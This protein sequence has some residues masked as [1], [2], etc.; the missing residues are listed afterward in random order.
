MR[1][2]VVDDDA[3]VRTLLDL[4]LQ[5]RGHEVVV[6]ASGAEA[7]AACAAGAFD[8]VLLDVTLPVFSVADL[9]DVLADDGA[10]PPRLALLSGI[11]PEEL[12]ALAAEHDAVPIAKPF[13]F[14]EL[15]AAVARLLARPASG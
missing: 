10:A 15:D 4:F 13:D 2:L 5:G 12:A 8:A 6:A 1:M 11:A 14:A 9:L 7:R 3:D